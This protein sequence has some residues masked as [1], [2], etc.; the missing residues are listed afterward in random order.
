MDYDESNKTCMII[1]R[2]IFWEKLTKMKSAKNSY[3]TSILK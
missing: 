3:V 2:L 1:F